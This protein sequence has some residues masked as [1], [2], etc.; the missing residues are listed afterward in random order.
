M[1][2]TVKVRSHP[3]TKS[4]D[5]TIPVE[6]ANKMGIQKG[7]IFQLTASE[8]SNGE[9]ILSYKRVFRSAPEQASKER[10][11]QNKTSYCHQCGT[12]MPD[13]ARFCNGCGTERLPS[14]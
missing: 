1:S 9:T 6:I 8:N 11:T 14:P 10:M 13:E 3:G 4:L 7:D 2:I 5:I 12:A